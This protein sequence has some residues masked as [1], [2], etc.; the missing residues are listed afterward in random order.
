VPNILDHHLI[1][2]FKNKSTFTK[3]ELRSFYE[4]FEPKLKESTL[5]WRIYDLKKT[6]VIR[7]LKRGLYTTQILPHY[8]PKIS[9]TLQNVLK[10]IAERYTEVVFCGW[11]TA[12][13]NSFSRH[14]ASRSIVI[15]E[16]E[17]DLLETLF[18]DLKSKFDYSL[19]INPSK[20]EIKYQIAED[21]DPIVIKKLITRSPIDKYRYENNV[22]KIPTIEKMMVDLLCDE[23][24]LYAYQGT[25]MF[26]IWEKMI[27]NYTF[28]FSQ[29]MTYAKRRQKGEYI[30]NML[31]LQMPHLV[32]DILDVD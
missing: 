29:M 1:Q 12:W 4:T 25:E 22:H 21:A 19:F 11:E 26:H 2:A 16:I 3:A 27:A 8:K 14:Q 6:R 5:K 28:D 15:I 30:R 7:E 9:I 17:K 24:L 23:D 32:K 10:T 18:F 20:D 13:L 31:V